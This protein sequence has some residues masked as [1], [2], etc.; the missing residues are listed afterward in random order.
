MAGALVLPVLAG[1]E[2]E[3]EDDEPVVVVVVV[4]GY[5]YLYWYSHQLYRYWQDS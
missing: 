4:A 2:D 3:A 5:R 1:A